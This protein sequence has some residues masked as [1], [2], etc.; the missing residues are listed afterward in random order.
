MNRLKLI[1]PATIIVGI[2]AYVFTVGIAFITKGF[3]IGVLSASL[4]ILSNIY[5]VYSFWNKPDT[6]YTP[7]LNINITLLVMVLSCLIVQ[8]IIKRFT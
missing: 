4:P 8:Q 2:V 7:Y 6:V 5:W 3:V 1:Y